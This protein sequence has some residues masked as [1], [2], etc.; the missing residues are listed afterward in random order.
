MKKPLINL[1]L[2]CVCLAGLSCLILSARPASSSP[3]AA[4]RAASLSEREPE[5]CTVIGV[6]RTGHGRRL[7]HHLPHGLLQRMPG[8]RRPRP[9]LSQG[10]PRSR[11]LGHGLFRRRGRPK[12]LPL[13][14]YGKVIGHIP[15]VEKT[16]AYFHTR[17]LPDERTAAGHR[18]EHLFPEAGALDVPFI[19]GLTKQIM[20]VEQAQV[21]ALERCTTAREA[22]G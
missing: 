8:P 15:Q 18:R 10:V 20:T 17:I 13:G 2:F 16:F 5:G 4:P 14:D 19:E 6:G 12:A 7:R 3:D 21:F 11:P 9:D 22:V 1:T